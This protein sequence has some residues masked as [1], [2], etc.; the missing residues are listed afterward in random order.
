MKTAY[1]VIEETDPDVLVEIIDLIVGRLFD[2]TELRYKVF[3]AQR[4]I[5]MRKD[6]SHESWWE[7]R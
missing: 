3:H 5:E 2:K 1:E 6:P 7:Q 4:V